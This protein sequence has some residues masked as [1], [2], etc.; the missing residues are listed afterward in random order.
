M[1]RGPRFRWDDACAAVGAVSRRLASGWVG[2]PHPAPC[3]PRDRFF[4][5]PRTRVSRCPGLVSCPPS[6]CARELVGSTH[7]PQPRRSPNPP[8]LSTPSGSPRRGILSM[9]FTAN[10]NTP[11]EE[12]LA[13][14]AP[15]SDAM[16][17]HSKVQHYIGTL[18]LP[19]LQPRARP[20]HPRRAPAHGRRKTR[21]CQLTAAPPLAPIQQAATR[22]TKPS[23]P[24]SPTLSA[25][26]AV[27]PSL[28]R[29]ALE[30]PRAR[31]K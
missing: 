22:S 14:D 31:K 9:P 1:G 19:L 11:A 29:C 18:V 23:R 5:R 7:R 21:A 13:P 25:L 4:R 2:C 26:E 30:L 10:A 17:D 28:Q 27:T 24:A 3:A 16:P 20:G 12:Q 8:K 15:S 6:L